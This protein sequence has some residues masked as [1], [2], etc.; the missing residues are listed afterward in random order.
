MT[1]GWSAEM[2]I[3]WYIAPMAQGQGRQAHVPHLPRPRDR[4]HRRTRGVAGG[5][6]RAPALP[7]R[8][9]ADR[10][11]RVQPGADR[12]HALRVGACTTTSRESENFDAGADIFWKPNGQFQ[13]TATI[14]PDFGQVESDDIVVNFSANETF[15]SDK[16]P[17]FTENQGPFEFTTPS[18]FSQLRLHA[19]RRRPGRR[20]QRRGRHHRGG[21]GQRQLRRDQLRRV[22]WPRKPIEVGRTFRALRLTPRLRQAERRHDGHAGG[23]PVFRSHRHGG[24]LRPELAPE[25]E[26]GTSRTA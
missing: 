21:Q 26:A 13:L 24:R 23:A 9:H 8:L 3:P 14:N 11:A 1:T 18:D 20:R 6:L 5:E 15:F 7:V 22:R 4:Q 17:F 19:P 16:R 10:S 2:L 25:P 12:D